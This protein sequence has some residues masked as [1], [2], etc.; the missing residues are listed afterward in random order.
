MRASGR[1][2]RK[3]LLNSA[4][5]LF[6]EHGFDKVTTRMIAE[7]AGIRLSSIHYHFVNKEN[8]YIEAF[9]YAR[10]KDT[11]VDFLE[12]LEEN[13]ELGTTPAGQAEIIRTTVLR[14]F[15]NV[16]HDDQPTWETQL[17]FREIVNPSSALPALAEKFFKPDVRNSEKFC[18]MIRPEIGEDEAA[19]WAQTLYAH[20]FLYIMARKP[21]ELI[22]GSKWLNRSFFHQAARMISRFMILELG[23]PLPDDLQQKHTPLKR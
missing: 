11:R 14:Y 12:V 9:R 4:G 3:K 10:N 23:L 2:T 8:L 17:L 18:R 5:L 1:D 6:A 19:I 20:L 13:P 16:F 22:R 7:S 15:R 21:I